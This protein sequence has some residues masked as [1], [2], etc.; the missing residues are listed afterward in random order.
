MPKTYRKTKDKKDKLIRFRVTE[1]EKELIE[2][3]SKF[4]NM[5]IGEY[6]LNLA[7]KDMEK[8]C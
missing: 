6:L 2:T 3:Y 7:F 1:Y 5:N 8:E 4:N